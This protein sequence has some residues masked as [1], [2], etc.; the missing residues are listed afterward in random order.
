MPLG[1]VIRTLFLLKYLNEPDLRRTIHAATNK[2]EQFNDFAQWLMFG[3]GRITVSVHVFGTLPTRKWALVNIGVF[4]PR[5][6]VQTIRASGPAVI[7]RTRAHLTLSYLKAIQR[8]GRTRF[9]ACATVQ[10]ECRSRLCCERWAIRY[11]SRPAPTCGLNSSRVS[12]CWIM[13][14]SPVLSA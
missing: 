14:S 8:A 3:G 4:V 12:E 9:D 6:A 1:R 11:P 10:R 5:T 13:M 7:G 2:S